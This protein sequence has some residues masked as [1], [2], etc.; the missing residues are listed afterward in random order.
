MIIAIID[1]QPVKKD[2]MIKA[3]PIIPL[4]TLSAWSA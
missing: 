1:G 2:V 4:M 3:D